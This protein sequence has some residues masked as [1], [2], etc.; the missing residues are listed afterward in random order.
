MFKNLARALFTIIF[1]AG[2]VWIGLPLNTS[3]ANFHQDTVVSAFGERPRGANIVITYNCNNDQ[4]VSFILTNDS[5]DDMPDGSEGTYKL[6]NADSSITDGT[7]F[8]PGTRLVTLPATTGNLIEI[9]YARIYN[10][11]P[12]TEQKLAD[13]GPQATQNSTAI[14]TAETTAIS[15]ELPTQV[16]TLIPTEAPTELAT[17]SPTVT[18]TTQI[19]ETAT[20]S[21]TQLATQAVSPS[22]TEPTPIV[23]PPNPDQPVFRVTV[24]CTSA[25]AANV[26]IK[27]KGADMRSPGTITRTIPGLSASF[28]NFRL[29]AGESVTTTAENNEIVIIQYVGISAASSVNFSQTVDCTPTPTPDPTES[30]EQPTDPVIAINVVCVDTDAANVTLSNYGGSMVASGD[31]SISGAGVANLDTSFQLVAG[32]ARDF[33]VQHGHTISIQYALPVAGGLASD[34]RTV[35][36][37]A[38]Q[39]PETPQ[40]PTLEATLQPTQVV[41]TETFQSEE[42]PVVLITPRV[43]MQPPT[44]I[45]ATLPVDELDLGPIVIPATSP[46]LITEPGVLIAATT[47]PPVSQCKDGSYQVVLTTDA[48]LFF[49]PNDQS[50]TK[51]IV[52]AGKTVSVVNIAN[53]EF[54]AIRWACTLYYMRVGTMGVNTDPVSKPFP[55]IP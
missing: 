54:A 47:P 17:Q 13:C 34:T 9:V 8:L 25:V 35:D 3:A 30:G 50:G 15:T 31:V 28:E 41:P 45:M 42:F 16:L 38:F 10:G 51:T 20:E 23:T 46:S 43:E 53:R 14:S 21:A 39:F 40:P 55:K 19:T 11:D 33:V 4:S 26:T 7:F 36:C 49:A 6:H 44:L 5:D 32:G 52:P 18:A 2:M 48:E 22:P 29:D 37:A 1:V 27:N 12:V 24:Q